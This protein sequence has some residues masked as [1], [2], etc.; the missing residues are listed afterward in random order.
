V[1]QDPYVYPGTD[2]LRNNFG[3]RSARELQRVEADITTIRLAELGYRGLPGRYD[4]DHLRAFHRQIFGEIYPW[5]GDIRTVAIAKGQMFALPQHIE[6]YLAEQLGHL[7]DEDYLQG[8]TH[9]SFVRRLTHYLAEINA[10]HP[11]R[12]GNGRTQR[13]FLGQLAAEADWQLAWSR[14]DAEE[15]IAASIA[16]LN[17]DNGPL[18][19]LLNELVER[20]ASPR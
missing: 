18:L 14:L 17:G 4:L 1:A 13:A 15:N 3:I 12:E 16:S 10:V 8:L 9:R 7:A 20:P 19:A 11:F 6:A 2:V 5:A